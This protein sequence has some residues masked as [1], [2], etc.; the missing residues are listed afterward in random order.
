M[1]FATRVRDSIV[2]NVYVKLIFWFLLGVFSALVLFKF[3][4]TDN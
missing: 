2:K 4:R 1:N 3:V